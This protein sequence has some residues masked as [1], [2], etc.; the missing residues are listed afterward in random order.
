ML[1]FITKN[2]YLWNK[3]KSVPTWLGDIIIL[4]IGIGA[5]AGLGIT[6]VGIFVLLG[7]GLH[8][9]HLVM[10]EGVPIWVM[11]VSGILILLIIASIQSIITANRND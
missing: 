4:V 3:D 2:K 6:V 7:L 8:S 5:F 11:V 9:I 10:G 1:E